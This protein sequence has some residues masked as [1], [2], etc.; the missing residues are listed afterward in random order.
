[1][2]LRWEEGTG[3]EEV[4]RGI[5]TILHSA[6]EKCSN[7]SSERVTKRQFTNWGDGE[8]QEK[9]STKDVVSFI[10]T[11]N[12][13]KKKNETVCLFVIDLTT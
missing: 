12:L 1:M 2:T 10:R 5:E 3:D 9:R 7:E 4:L 11:F 8:W 6:Q 13:K